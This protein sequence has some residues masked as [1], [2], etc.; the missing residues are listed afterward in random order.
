MTDQCLAYVNEPICE[1]THKHTPVQLE[2]HVFASALLIFWQASLQIPAG[3]LA[4]LLTRVERQGPSK[5]EAKFAS[6][7]QWDTRCTALQRGY[8]SPTG[9]GRGGSHSA[10]VSAI[11]N[12]VVMQMSSRRLSDLMFLDFG[13]AFG[14]QWNKIFQAYTCFIL[15]NMF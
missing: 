12:V 4:R 1:P 8:A 15:L 6:P 5:C 13:F 10:N 3:T 2:G 14:L 11:L 9:P 7:A